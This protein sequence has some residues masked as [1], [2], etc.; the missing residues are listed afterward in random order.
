MLP[1]EKYFPTRYS[2]NSRCF[3]HHTRKPPISGFSQTRFH[4]HNNQTFPR[5]I[6]TYHPFPPFPLEDAHDVVQGLRG[7]TLLMPS[8]ADSFVA[9]S[10]SSGSMVLHTAGRQP[11]AG[12]TFCWVDFSWCLAAHRPAVQ[13]CLIVKT[14]GRNRSVKFFLHIRIIFYVYISFLFG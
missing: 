3:P 6:S 4:P 14:V 10:L 12:S 7:V 11:R 1:F 2:P 8:L 5:P 9:P 13:S